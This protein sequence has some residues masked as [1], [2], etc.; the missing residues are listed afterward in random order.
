MCYP[1]WLSASHSIKSVMDPSFALSVFQSKWLRISEPIWAMDLPLVRLDSFASSSLGEED[2]QPAGNCKKLE[3][4]E[5]AKMATQTSL[6]LV[7]P[8]TR[9]TA[10]RPLHLENQVI[11]P[12]S[13]LHCSSS[14]SF[15]Q[16]RDPVT[17][18]RHCCRHG[19]NISLTG[20]ASFPFFSGLR[21][22]RWLAKRRSIRG[23]CPGTKEL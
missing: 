21:S 13:I 3:L 23:C 16:L 17:V 22:G 4:K 18:C 6:N 15:Q 14:N 1:K 11:L 5:R 19:D 8:F 10:I 9:E 20:S 7:P 12:I 2:F